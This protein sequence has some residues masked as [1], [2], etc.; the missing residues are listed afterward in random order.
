M[1]LLGTAV[2]VHGRVLVV[3]LTAHGVATVLVI[4][5]SVHARV[6]LLVILAS[7]HARA[8]LGRLGLGLALGRV[9]HRVG[10]ATRGLAGLVGVLA[11]LVFV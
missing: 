5:A 2:H 6:H 1:L 11:G 7:V 10:D 8:A 3:A 9:A 4:L